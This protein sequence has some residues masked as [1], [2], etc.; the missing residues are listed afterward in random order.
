MVESLG[1]MNNLFSYTIQKR[2]IIFFYVLGNITKKEK[3]NKKY[4]LEDLLLVCII[5]NFSL[6]NGIGKIFSPITIGYNWYWRS[7]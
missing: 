5:K 2:D 7:N 1:N 3:W 6:K 4:D